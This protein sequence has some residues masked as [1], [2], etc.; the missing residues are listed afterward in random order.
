MAV[1]SRRSP[2]REQ[3]R[4]KRHAAVRARIIAATVDLISE[5]ANY[6]ALSVETIAARSG[7]SRTTFYDY[8]PDK[9]ELLLAMSVDVL[10]DALAGVDDW[11]PTGDHDQTKAEFREL[12]VGLVEAYHHPAVRAI[13]EATSYDEEVRRAWHENMQRHIGQVTA[14]VQLEHDAG[15]FQEH[16]STVPA[17]ARALHWT[18]H[19]TILQ[20]IVLTQTIE[21]DAL[22]DALV[23]VCVVAV[24]GVLP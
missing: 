9:R 3:A 13:V 23:D 17:R 6:A 1:L 22:I 16:G 18:V 14:V 7:I 20:E 8:F 15:R 10:A 11:H 24:R 12:V 4:R 19:A 21:R 5:G 2:E